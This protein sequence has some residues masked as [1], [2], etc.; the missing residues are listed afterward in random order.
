[1]AKVIVFS[2]GCHSGKTTTLNK[3]A[4]LLEKQGYEV[5]KLSELMRN[6]MPTKS[7]DEL[8]KDALEY[9]ATQDKII[10]EKM[11]QETV[12]FNDTSNC[13]Y[14]VDRAITDSMFYLTHYV[15]KSQLNKFGLELFTKLYFEVKMHALKAFRHGGYDLLIEFEPIREIK[16]AD[17]YR[18]DNMDLMVEYEADCISMINTAFS[19]IG[20]VKYFSYFHCIHTPQNILSRI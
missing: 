16:I 3:V 9:L 7:I 15:D 11:Q 1:M 2:G 8:R 12:A 4:E 20:E 18:P 6:V 10:S 17:V 19:Q 13:I 5:K 14:L